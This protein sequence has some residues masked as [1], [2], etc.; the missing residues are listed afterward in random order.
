MKGIMQLS[1]FTNFQQI[2]QPL[3]YPAESANRKR[4]KRQRRVNIYRTN[5]DDEKP[6]CSAP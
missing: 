1:D 4:T 6:R 2:N 3:I 5:E